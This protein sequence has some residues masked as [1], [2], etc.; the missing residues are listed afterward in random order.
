MKRTFL[1]ALIAAVCAVA[2][3]TL[4]AQVIMDLGMMDKYRAVSVKMKLQDEATKEA[5]GF[6]SVYLIPVGDT[7]VTNFALSDEK[8]VVELDEVLSGKYELNAEIIGYHPYKKVHEFSRWETDLGIIQM[9]ENKEY[10]DAST[11]TAVGNPITVRQDTLEFNASSYQVGENAMLADLLK[12]MPGMEVD[13]DG[14]V[15]VNGETVDKVTVG[16]KTFFFKDP[17]MAV[18]NLPAKIVDKIKVIDKKTTEAEKTGIATDD[19]KE[20]VM[21]VQLKEEYTKGWF[22]NAKAGGGYTF[23]PKTGDD[24]VDHRGLLYQGN[25]MVSGYNEKDQLVMIASGQNATD[26]SSRTAVVIFSGSDFDDLDQKR[27]LNSGANVGV[28][29]NTSRIKNVES[30][31]AVSYKYSQKDAKERSART[32]YEADDS[33][34][35]TN[36]AFN[37]IGDSHSVSASFQFINEESD[38]YYFNIEPTLSFGTKTRDISNVSATMNER[39]TL[40]SS[41]S[42]K[43]SDSKSLSGNIFASLGFLKLGGKDKRS[44]GVTFYGGVSDMDGRSYENSVLKYAAGGEVKNLMYDKNGRGGSFQGSISYVEPFAKDWMLRV[45]LTANYSGNMSDDEAFNV[46][47]MSAND[48]YSSYSKNDNVSL[49][50]RLLAQYAKDSHTLHAG[51]SFYEILNVIHAKTLGVETVTGKDDWMFR[52]APSLRYNYQKNSFRTSVYYNFYSQEPQGSQISPILNISNPTQVSTGNIYLQPYFYHYADLELAYNDSKT[53]SFVNFYGGA[54]LM[55]NPVVTAS[56]FDDNAIR[57]SVPVNSLRPGMNLYATATYNQPFGKERH[58]TFST[59]ATVDYSDN[60]SYQAK[61]RMKGMDVSEFDYSAFM[62]DF[63]GNDKGDRFYGGESG[64]AESNT[65]TLH[66]A[67]DMG[68][69]Y[70]LDRFSVEGHAY[71]RNQISRYSL[72]HTADMNT[73]MHSYS[74]ET[75]YSTKSQWEF[76]TKLVYVMYRGYSDGFGAPELRWNAS[77]SK[78][79]KSVTLSL[80]GIDLL[81]QTRNLNRVVTSDYMQDTYNN[82]MGR[83]V[84]FSVAF[85][86]G[87]MNAKKASAV[88]EAMWR[89][90]F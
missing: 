77:I 46:A 31:G 89:T 49:S 6:V 81:N 27:G 23:T 30:S 22:G 71:A 64:F 38:K 5:I 21:D 32:S 56:W 11:I 80:K 53:Y 42:T 59:Y 61:T 84:L 58:F 8:G 13:D 78:T 7:T 26:P 79:I 60:T 14:T 35:Y 69:K 47:D 39:D 29:L 41:V 51:L 68:L 55:Q 82:V 4:S 33:E 36:G 9:K 48:Y 45:Q 66:Y 76:N 54:R 85:N 15:K 70:Q 37:G 17:T 34:L 88:E 28:N 65:N 74:F 50:G 87:K 12:K 2:A 24:L 1:T 75:L 44:L 18:K 16:G 73:W 63:W 3:H 10:I 83:Y 20:K 57:Y 25:A 43:S 52:W 90:A 40:N 67:F 72:D 19:D 62:S 86:F